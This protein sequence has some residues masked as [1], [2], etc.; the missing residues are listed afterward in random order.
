MP[1]DPTNLT[2][3][4]RRF[5]LAFSDMLQRSIL[6][7]KYRPSYTIAHLANHDG[8]KTA[9]WLVNIPDESSGFTRL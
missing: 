1:D 8:G 5:N 4:R 7:I 6:E 9:T 3:L 2:D